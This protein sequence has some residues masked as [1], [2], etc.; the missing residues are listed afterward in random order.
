MTTENPIEFEIEV[1]AHDATPED[2]DG[3]TRN[4]LRELRESDVESARLLSVGSAPKGTKAGESIT[5][6]MLAIEVLPSVLPSVI[7]LVQG[8]VTRGQGRTVKFKGKGI[9]FEGPPEELYKLLA[10]LEKGKEK[11]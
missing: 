3:M 2:L 9:E 1:T 4:L 5:I 10:T 8:W 6:G 7:G 11:E